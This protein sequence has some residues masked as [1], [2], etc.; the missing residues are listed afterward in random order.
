M[1]AMFV[2]R[3]LLAK[4]RPVR[5]LFGRMAMFLTLSGL[6]DSYALSSGQDLNPGGWFDL[7]WSALLVIPIAIAATWRNTGEGHTGTAKDHRQSL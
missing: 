4:S 3:A 6:A 5:S 7:C 2:L 1:V